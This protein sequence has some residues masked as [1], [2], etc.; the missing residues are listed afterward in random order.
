MPTSLQAQILKR[1]APLYVASLLQGV[2]L[3]Y[4]IEKLFMHQLGFDD[5][6]IG[7][8]V[9][10][11]SAVMLIVETPSG[12]L[13]DRWSRK[14]V[15]V[16]ASVALAI[17]SILGGMSHSISMYLLSAACWGIFFALYSGTYDSI[18][19]DTLLETE[20]HAK[21]YEFYYGRVRIADSVG[22]VGSSLL[23]GWIAAHFGVRDSYY[24]SVL[25]ALLSI[26]PLIMFREPKLHKK[27]AI[28]SLTH[29]IKDTFRAMTNHRVLVLILS[30]L[31]LIE[32][33]SYSM[34]EFAQLWWIALAFP[35]AAF[36]LSNAFLLT[37]I[38]VGGWVAGR[39]KL[40]KLTVMLAAVGVMLAAALGL[41]VLHSGWLVVACQVVIAT[42]TVALTVLF[43]R[44][45]HDGLP[46]R[47]RAGASSA[48]STL[49]RV[50]I[51]PFALLFGWISK[52][53]GIYS[54]AW[55]VVALML[56]VIFVAAKTLRPGAPLPDITGE[57][58]LAGPGY[59]K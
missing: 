58:T 11:Y 32:A 52:E 57:D 4:N 25:P 29:H 19:Y 46:S 5:A 24:W 37:A 31:V 48:V 27:H 42:G 55:T 23:G 38:G 14:G 51:I 26:V 36:G 35:V 30:G 3:W 21:R 43:T 13:A 7:I 12:I 44:L 41:V 40:Q 6:G 22:L 10:A 28:I 9:A 8:M 47:V 54:A 49:T 59:N 45:L 18:V 15:L 34:F 1:L 20:G 39:L 17:S 56:A 33:L 2:V 53:A 16:I 50:V